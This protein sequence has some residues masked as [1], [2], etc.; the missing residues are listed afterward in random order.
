MPFPRS[1]GE[2][3]RQ[4]G[5]DKLKPLSSQDLVGSLESHGRAWA[6]ELQGS[7][8]IEEPRQPVDLLSQQTAQRPAIKSDAAGDSS[9]ATHV[10]P[11]F[12]Y[13]E[14]PCHNGE[15][16]G[17][18]FR[19]MEWI[20]VLSQKYR[21]KYVCNPGD[22]ETGGHSTGNVGALFGC[23]RDRVW[24]NSTL[25]ASRSA[26]KE[27]R[28]VAAR[29]Q[30][31][32]S[33]K[34]L[35]RMKGDEPLFRG[36]AHQLNPRPDPRRKVPVVYQLRCPGGQTTT[37]EVSWQWLQ[38][39]YNAVRIQ[40]NRKPDWGSATFRIAL[41]L[42][43]GDRP[44]SC[45][46]FLYLN[47]L[48]YLFA[49]I[50]EIS[51]ENVAISVIG[52]LD[53]GSREFACLSQIPNLTF[54]AGRALAGGG[55]N[56]YVRLKRD[57]DFIASSNVLVLGGGG[58]FPSFTATL[59]TAG[60]IILHS[61]TKDGGVD[62]LPHAFALDRSGRF[63]CKLSFDMFAASVLGRPRDKPRP[64]EGRP[65]PGYSLLSLQ[66]EKAVEVYTSWYNTAK[67]C[68]SKKPRDGFNG[69]KCETPAFTL[70][71]L[72]PCEAADLPVPPPTEQTADTLP[73][74][75]ILPARPAAKVT[76]LDESPLYPLDKRYLSCTAA[77]KQ[78]R[79]LAMPDDRESSCGLRPKCCGPAVNPAGSV[80][81]PHDRVAY[82]FQR[83]GSNINHD[84][85]QNFWPLYWWM[86]QHGQSNETALLVDRACV[87]RSYWVD[88][89]FW[90]VARARGW[91]AYNYTGGIRYCA[92]KQLHI[93]RSVGPCCDYSLK[94]KALLHRA[95]KAIWL[96]VLGH[97]RVSLDDHSHVVIYS[98]GKSSWRR[99]VKPEQLTPLFHS[100]LKVT[101]H[102]DVPATLVQQ[103]RFFSSAAA[104][105]APNGGWAPNALF[106]ASDACLIELHLYKEDSWVVDYGLGHE[107][108]EVLLIVGNYRD[109]TKQRIIRRA[110][111][112]GD[113]DFLVTGGK[114]NLF[115]DIRRKMRRSRVCKQYLAT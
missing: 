86:T 16:I 41:Q 8:L 78:S 47:A 112:G 68:E 101:I 85:H 63:T 31:D 9:H 91:R 75:K 74:S 72:Q 32:T 54:L 55:S 73:S 23:A 106:M 83:C 3:S 66:L 52:E 14:K 105:L 59:Q 46:L 39:Q 5:Q 79:C 84:F 18:M 80:V 58:S 110:R 29:L 87:N 100:R 102:D 19:R 43:R 36:T 69:K 99:I 17:G 62:G 38:A 88:D 42:R 98:R 108:G 96:A 13:N 1:V 90:N 95:K 48:R 114:D 49:A 111:V 50:P 11:C 71:T 56:G 92:R 61:R 70:P 60:G 21:C 20:L 104:V 82:Y 10:P 97:D 25:I 76:E 94:P 107:I 115:N 30:S 113:D 44:D 4:D 93:M 26:L 109:P 45:P 7:D 103:A 2:E 15:G 34:Y 28:F 12:L 64:S 65:V 89:L 51:P 27:A 6:E 22:W 37:H 81:L 53:P 40:E 57:L 77:C 67:P 33:S 35:L 24:G